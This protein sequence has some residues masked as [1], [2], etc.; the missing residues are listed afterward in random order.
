MK[1]AGRIQNWNT[2]TE[3]RHPFLMTVSFV[4]SGILL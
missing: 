2:H 1:L 4:V 3:E